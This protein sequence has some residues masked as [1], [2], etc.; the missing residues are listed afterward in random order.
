MGGGARG[1]THHKRGM[2][3]RERPPTIGSEAW[4]VAAGTAAKDLLERGGTV[5]LAHL[6]SDPTV[7]LDRRF[8]EI[9]RAFEDVALGTMRRATTLDDTLLLV[10]RQLCELLDVRRCSV[11]LRRDD[12]RFEGR[13]AWCRGQDIGDRIR[14]LVA[15]VEGDA[16]TH[17]IVSTRA[18][19]LVT[20][21][22]RDPRT[23]RRTMERWQVRDMLGVPLVVDEDVIGII[24][25]DN[26]DEKHSYGEQEIAIAQAF[27]SLAA[28]AVRQRWLHSELDQRARVIDRQRAML[29][30]LADANSRLTHAVLDGADLHTLLDLIRAIVGKPVLLYAADRRLM[31]WSAPEELY[32]ERPPDL[33]GR[34]QRGDW[35]ERAVGAAAGSRSPVMVPPAPH[36]GMPGRQLVCPLTIDR[37]HVGSLHVVELGRALSTF[38]TKVLERAAVVV[39]LQ[40]LTEHRQAEAEGQARQ[41][42]LAD[43]LHG[44]RSADQLR[45][46][47]PL[48]GV[49]PSGAHVV[50]RVAYEETS[51]EATG[52]HRRL[53]TEALVREVV[54]ASRTLLSTGVPGADLFLIDVGAEELEPLEAA[55]SAGFDRL[56]EGNTRYAIVSAPCQNLDDLPSVATELRELS[57][58]LRSATA[59]PQVVLSR[60]LSLVR[61]ATAAS[62]VEEARRFAHDLLAAV[63]A[64][65][66]DDGPLLD[67]LRSYLG[68]EGRIRDTSRSLGVHE[69]TVRY[70]LARIRDLTGLDLDRLDALAEARFALQVLELLGELPAER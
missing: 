8:A 45:R 17:E 51:D 16:F 56:R 4:C 47:A 65:D 48:F 1:L 53:R 12:G 42:F 58:L 44:Y 2:A 39:S 18:P 43:L 49:E 24:Y 67:T 9:L 63:Q 5:T 66:G 40:L 59:P 30:R 32:L 60:R 38:D 54:G 6:L 14:P 25:V 64:H 13:A 21:A 20:D 33:T 23:I 34:A 37:H 28:V 61:L 46:R 50:L 26:E 69:N 15:G 22:T 36:L 55:L 52:S 19:V 10:G 27:A 57:E 68:C 29:E 7:T 31:G 70:R 35:L 41:D 3:L 62:G 11:Y